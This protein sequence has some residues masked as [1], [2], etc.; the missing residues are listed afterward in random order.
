MA[1][2]LYLCLVTVL[3]CGGS[4]RGQGTNEGT[5]LGK[6]FTPVDALSTMDDGSARLDFAH[7]QI[8]DTPASCSS[9][10]QGAPAMC[11]GVLTIELTDFDPATR[12]STVPAQPGTYTVIGVFFGVDIPP[13]PA[14]ATFVRPDAN[15]PPDG[16]SPATFAESGTI[17][18]TRIDGGSFSGTYDMLMKSGEHVTGSFST[19]S[20]K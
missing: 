20:C 4:S 17:T 14:T 8:S 19:L 11:A 6:P 12:T 2:H 3:A 5:L 10:Q 18:L 15:C 7:I 16:M 1:N 9:L 13:K